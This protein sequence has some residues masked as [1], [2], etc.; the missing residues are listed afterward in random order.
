FGERGSLGS[1][2]AHVKETPRSVR[3]LRPEVP[4]WLAAIVGRLL[5]KSPSR[6]LRSA[7]VVRRAL[8]KERAPIDGVRLMRRGLVVLLLVAAAGTFWYVRQRRVER[9]VAEG[10]GI[11]AIDS[12]NRRLW[13]REGVSLQSAAI[14][15]L[16]G[17]RRAVAALPGPRNYSPRRGREELLILDG[18]RGDLIERKPV[19]D[20]AAHFPG[21]ADDFSRGGIVPTDVDHDGISELLITYVHFYYPSVTVIY[22]AAN[23][24]MHVLLVASGHHHYAGTVD[25]NGDGRD[26]VILSGVNNKMG[27]HTAVAAV[28]LLKSEGSKGLEDPGVRTPDTFVQAMSAASTELVW[29]ALLPPGYPAVVIDREAAKIE[30]RYANGQAFGIGMDGFLTNHTSTL[31]SGA[32]QA[33]RQQAFATL[34]NAELL[35]LQGDA[36]ACL[37]ESRKAEDQARAAEDLYLSQWAS[38]VHGRALIAAGH[39]QEAEARFATLAAV[40]GLESD[41]SFDAAHQ[42]HLSGRYEEALRWYRRAYLSGADRAVGRMRYESVEGA[43][44]LLAETGQLDRAARLLDE[45]D[46]LADNYDMTVYRNFVAWRRGM[47][48]DA[49]PAANAVATDLTRYWQLEFA[50]TLGNDRVTLLRQVLD[51]EARHGLHS[52]LIQ[53]LKAQLLLEAGRTAEA[54]DAIRLAKQWHD[55]ERDSDITARA[56]ASLIDERLQAI[57]AR[58]DTT[59]QR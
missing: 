16:P 30:V 12:T 4:R 56:H 35:R 58:Q 17:G 31:P 22:E 54:L 34:R 59:P 52:G 57:V 9:I 25:V 6:R 32:R 37:A 10:T 11:V 8:E 55:R 44:L 23:N 38:R 40:D 42:Y 41:V 21:F 33:R 48:P 39:G 45:Y 19:P 53:S 24:R 15:T 1:I 36:A 46:R 29:Y 20:L 5:E 51:E 13:V 2:L 49:R 50:H 26:E 27:W 7:T 3:K 18:V 47:P 43:V 28:G 14:I